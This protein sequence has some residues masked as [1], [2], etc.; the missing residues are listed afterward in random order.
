MGKD[1]EGVCELLLSAANMLLF[2][3]GSD[4][5]DVYTL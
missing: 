2:A 1:W 3:L 4:Y 5:T